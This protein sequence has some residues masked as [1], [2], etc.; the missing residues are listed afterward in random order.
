MPIWAFETDCV[1]SD[2]ESINAMNDTA[3][4]IT[5]RTMRK[6]VGAALDERASELGY[7]VGAQRG[8]LRLSKDWAVSYWKGTYRGRAC[9]FFRWSHIEQIFTR[10]TP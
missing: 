1:N 10:S 3:K 8:G 2:G 4:E 9:Y 7:D 6:A 5:Y